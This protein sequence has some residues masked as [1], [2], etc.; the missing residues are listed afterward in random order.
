MAKR[1]TGLHQLTLD[2]IATASVGRH[3][4]GGGLY[5]VV[6][7]SGKSWSFRYMQRGKQTWM[8][9]GPV[10]L[11]RL[12]DN[13][14][15]VR[16]AAARCRAQLDS[17]H[18]PLKVRREAKAAENPQAIPTFEKVA[19][20]Y[21]QVHAHSWKNE[22][23]QQQWTSTLKTYVYPVIGKMGVDVVR[24]PHIEM[25]LRPIWK[26]T[27]ETAKRVRGRIEAILDYAAGK[28]WRPLESNPARQKLV[29]ALLGRRKVPVK[30]Q[31]SLPYQ[32]VP[33]F[34]AKLLKR[35]DVPALSLAWIIFT[36]MRSSEGR[37]ALKSEIATDKQGLVVWS[38]PAVRMKKERDHKV[39]LCDEV[40]A[41][42]KRLPKTDGDFL[43][44]G[45]KAGQCISDTALRNVLRDH[46]I[47]AEKASIHGFRA[48]FR[49]WAADTHVPE[50]VA[51]ACLAHAISD[52][53]I[54]AYQRSRFDADR[55]KVM[56]DWAV[57]VTS[58]SD[59]E[60]VLTTTESPGET[61]LAFST[62][63]VG[64]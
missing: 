63:L 32:D 37:G 39:P 24:V 13:L 20:A 12:A 60:T 42:R 31:A 50:Q 5:L 15:Q 33:D 1:R 43:F 30:N 21:I 40:V 48:S 58:K 9:L 62:A 27:Y 4:D 56:K 53:V 41:L 26:K 17:G 3:H 55:R 52:K 45:Q 29:T 57:Y 35:D 47:K 59:P 28:G 46:G 14:K 23:H 2:D 7:P 34:M 18:N 16:Q 38:V 6:R 51:E 54:A 36:C 10:N 8:G 44:P 64:S 49:T 19:E 22:R 25:I 11:G 61:P